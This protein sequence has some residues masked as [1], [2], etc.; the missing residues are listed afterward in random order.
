[1]VMR[2]LSSSSKGCARTRFFFC[3]RLIS[4]NPCSPA[5][6]S[7]SSS[8]VF[9]SDEEESNRLLQSS[10]DHHSR[11]RRVHILTGNHHLSSNRPL[12]ASPVSSPSSSISFSDEHD[13]DSCIKPLQTLEGPHRHGC[14][15]PAKTLNSHQNSIS[16]WPPPPGSSSFSFSDDEDN[17]SRSSRL[18]TL[19]A[20]NTISVF[21]D[22][23]NKPP[24]SVPPYEAAIRLREVACSFGRLVDMV[25]YANRHAF[26]YLPSYVREERRHRKELDRLEVSGLVVPAEPYVCGYCGRKCKTNMALK[27][28]FKQLHERERNKRLNRLDSLKGKKKIKYKQSLTEKETRYREASR[29]IITPKVGY[30]LMQEI[31]R[32]GVWVKMV[33][34]RPQA[35]DEALTQHISQSIHMGIKCICLVSDDSDFLPVL[36]EAR[37]CRLRTVVIG[38][39]PR[40]KMAA[41]VQFSWADLASGRAFDK[42]ME[43]ATMWNVDKGFVKGNLRAGPCPSRNAG[44]P[45]ESKYVP[46]HTHDFQ[47]F[48]V[49][50]CSDLESGVDQSDAE[51][52]LESSPDMWLSEDEDVD[53]DD[54]DKDPF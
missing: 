33:S 4:T 52:E 51:S 40:L 15:R 20:D 50:D 13:S 25:A 21:W 12:Q 26:S 30:G 35:A 46:L 22:L 10:E 53:D 1:M 9:F 49:S 23:D 19:D 5:S 39:K 27:K 32:A 34:D 36:H 17:R 38:D 3:R 28:H 2:V 29:D 14:F 41:D 8:P 42:A 37:A 48:D 16:Y 18:R 24:H 47:E 43:L 7:S 44:V 54:D 6:P 11:N 45:R 31:K